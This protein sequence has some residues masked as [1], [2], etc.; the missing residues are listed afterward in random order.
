MAHD[1]LDE[2]CVRTAVYGGPCD[3]TD[4]GGFAWA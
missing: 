4:A 1:L 3:A 2:S